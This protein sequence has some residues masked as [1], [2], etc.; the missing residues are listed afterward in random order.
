VWGPVRCP[1]GRN[2]DR[3]ALPRYMIYKNNW[4]MIRNTIIK[5]Q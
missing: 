4:D 2:P 5:V 1:V 3:F